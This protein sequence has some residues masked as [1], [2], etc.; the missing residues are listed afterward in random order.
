M[1]DGEWRRAFADLMALLFHHVGTNRLMG[2]V[3]LVYLL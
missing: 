2:P 1:N 3:L